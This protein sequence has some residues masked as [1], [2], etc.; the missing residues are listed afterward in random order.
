MDQLFPK[1]DEL[2]TAYGLRHTFATALE[3][4]GVAPIMAQ[5][6]LGHRPSA[7]THGTYSAG[8]SL[9]GMRAALE[10]L[11]FPQGRP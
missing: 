2:L 6:L 7:M 9:E 8:A 5:R 1:R 11:D 10:K 3:P 4:A